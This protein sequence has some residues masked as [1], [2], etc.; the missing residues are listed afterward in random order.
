MEGEGSKLGQE[1]GESECVCVHVCGSGS[2]GGSL[3]LRLPLGK[4]L[5]FRGDAEERER[6]LD[7]AR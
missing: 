2:G 7:A 5:S 6:R 4:H 1:H 3:V